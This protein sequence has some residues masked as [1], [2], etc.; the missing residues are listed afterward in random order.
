VG[1]LDSLQN[2]IRMLWY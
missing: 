1:L 2:L